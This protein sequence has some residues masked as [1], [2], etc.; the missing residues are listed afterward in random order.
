M[1]GLCRKD[2]FNKQDTSQY[3]RGDGLMDLKL[4]IGIGFTI[5]GIVTVI[6]FTTPAAALF[7]ISR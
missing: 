3:Q 6:I 5:A 2:I 4:M 7:G 1:P